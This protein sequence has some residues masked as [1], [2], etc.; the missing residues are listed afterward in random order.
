MQDD[1]F[2]HPV[3]ELDPGCDL[4][5]GY[6]DYQRLFLAAYRA[7]FHLH[8]SPS[9]VRPY[10]SRYLR[11]YVVAPWLRDY[12]RGWPDDPVAAELAHAPLDPQIDLRGL[13]RWLETALPLV[14]VRREA[15]P[16]GKVRLAA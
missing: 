9:R 5:H 13:A 16:Y 8:A 2:A 4:A 3:W 7:T 12:A 1:R 15:T 14:Y 11:F 10:L 6:D